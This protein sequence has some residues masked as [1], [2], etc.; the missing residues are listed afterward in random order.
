MQP[1]PY[2]PA[3]N[4]AD[5]E[6]NNAGGRS[7]V[8]TDRLD[9]E[10]EAI[11]VT[12]DGLCANLALLQRDDGKLL[13]G[14]VEPYNLSAATRAYTQATKWTV[15]GLWATA[16]SY[17]VNDMV[18]VSGASYICAT[19]HTSGVFAA[20]YAAG[21]WQIFV[22]ANNASAQ[23]FS[24]TATI[25]ALNTQA[26]IEEVDTKLRAASIPSLAAFYGGF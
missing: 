16:T 25:S 12:T 11:E 2:T 21:K 26:A 5:D 15:R 9:A 24:P 4:F 20:D 3:N 18:D 14:L 17:S 23:A 7:T 8:R 6:R 1:T 10:L 13:D 19:A 22:S